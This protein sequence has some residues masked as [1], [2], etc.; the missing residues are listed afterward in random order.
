MRRRGADES[1]EFKG[2]V[3][4]EFDSKEVADTFLQTD[5]VE[6]EGVTLTKESK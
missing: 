4:V 1:R 3:F 6:F 5:G 2:S